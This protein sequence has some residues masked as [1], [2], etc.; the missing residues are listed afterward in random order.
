M[1]ITPVPHPS[2]ALSR[3]RVL[4][5]LLVIG[6]VVVLALVPTVLGLHR[7]VVADDA[8]SGDLDDSI[9]RG[10]IALTREVP[11]ADLEV[12]DVVTF[13]PPAVAGGEP[14]DPVTRRI[15]GLADGVAV[16]RADSAEDDDPWQLDVT[17]DTYDQVVFVVPWLGYPFTGR[18]GQGGWM[19]LAITAIFALLLAAAGSARQRREPGGGSTFHAFP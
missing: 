6:P 13:R 18:A 15:V 4:V 3:G 10:S 17:H 2:P 14:G 1:E 16:T 12:G 7:Y 8:M 19:I 5:A 9:T 11:A